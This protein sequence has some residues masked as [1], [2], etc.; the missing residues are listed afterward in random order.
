MRSVILKPGREKSVL[1][2]HPW[3]FSGA[4]TSLPPFSDGEV[5]S[6]HA[7]NGT[8]L[9]KAFFHSTNSISGRILTFEDEPTET[10]LYKRLD[11]AIAIRSKMFNPAL[12]NCFRLVNAEGDGLSGLIVDLY[13]TVGVIQVTTKG[14]E[15]LKEKII[16]YLVNKLP[17][18]AIFEK[19]ES[20]A[21]IQEGLAPIT[22]LVYGQMPETLICKENGTL[23]YIDILKGQKTGFF[24][25][26]REMRKL[27]YELKPKRV[28]NCF[29]YSGGFSLFALKAGAQFV[30]SVDVSEKAC[31]LALQ[32]SSLNGF[33]GHKVTCCDVFD[34]LRSSPLDFDLVILDPPAFAKKRSDVN[35]AC[36]GYKEINRQVL[37]KIPS[38]SYL[39]T[40]SCSHFVDEQLFRQVVFQAA[41]EAG[42]SVKICSSHSQAWDHPISI[43]HKEGSYLKSLLLLVT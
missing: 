29:A 42:R 25:D 39:L 9:A 19:S 40:S 33:S 11:E 7:S 23:F 4:I 26:Q 21:R 27:V 8:F 22:G 30:E 2:R 1:N 35:D 37:Q 28:L 36:R 10:A 32:N 24:L 14:M 15:L 31:Q 17:V 13:D 38:G 43:Y 41:V 34:Y 5:L 3:I 6:V 12:T 18:V 20:Q 16:A